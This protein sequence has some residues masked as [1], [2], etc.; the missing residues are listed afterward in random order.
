MIICFVYKQNSTILRKMYN[1]ADEILMI[2][3]NE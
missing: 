2:Y 3:S 1:T